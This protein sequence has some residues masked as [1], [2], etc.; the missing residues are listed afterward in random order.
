MP[1]RPGIQK[2]QYRFFFYGLLS[3]FFLFSACQTIPAGQPEFTS[4]HLEKEA[5]APEIL[6]QILNARRAGLID[7]KSFVRT[8]ITNNESTHSFKQALLVK[9]DSSLR[10]D[11]LG[12]FGQP[13]GVFIYDQGKTLLY[14][15]QQNRMYRGREAWNIMEKIV[16]TVIDFDEYISLLTGNVPCIRELKLAAGQ[17]SFDKKHYQLETREASGNSRFLVDMD[18]STLVPVKLVKEIDFR[19]VYKVEWQDYK[20]L[21]NYSFP[22]QVK[23]TRFINEEKLVIMYRQPVINSGITEESFRFSPP[24]SQ[25][26]KLVTF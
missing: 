4:P 2:P 22:H 21:G 13:K 15:T 5:I 20:K 26:A 11:T 18:A 1:Q 7:L 17:L 10:L 8:T 16:G 12:V 9:N 3:S 24:R 25:A 23:L 6:F 19:D 14:D